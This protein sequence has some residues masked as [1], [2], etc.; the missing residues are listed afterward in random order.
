MWESDPHK[1][2]GEERAAKE[3]FVHSKVMDWVAME[4]ASKMAA[5]I[6]E[7]KEAR[8]FKDVSREIRE[9]I[10]EKGI[11]EDSGRFVSYY[12]SDGIDSS[13]LTLPLYGFV[14]ANDRVFLATLEEIEKRLMTRSGLLLRYNTDFYGR[15]KHPFILANTWLARVYSRQGRTADARGI[16]MKILKCSGSLGLLG[17]HADAKTLEPRGNFPQMFSHAG[18]IEAII[19]YERAEKAIIKSKALPH[20]QI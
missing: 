3:H 8:E 16:I 6:N 9:D 17:E 18:L 19:E 13:L 5:A 7:V 4:R 1:R 20:S 2:R 15:T 10:L 12:G 14:E 11:S